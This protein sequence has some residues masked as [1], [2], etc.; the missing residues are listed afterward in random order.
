MV[1]VIST[2]FRVSNVKAFISTFATNPTYMA[3]GRTRPWVPTAASPSADDTNPPIAIDSGKDMVGYFRELIGAKRIGSADVSAAIP[4]FNWT[5]GTIYTQY[6]YTDQDITTKNMFVVINDSLSGSYLNVYKCI[7][8]ANGVASSIQPTGT[9]TSVIGPLADG[10]KWKFMFQI[11]SG[12]MAKF[13]TSKFLPIKEAPSGSLQEAVQNS[14]I[15]G[16]IDTITV[17]AP[18]T[19]YTTAPSI[20]ITGDGTGATAVASVLAGAITAITITNPGTG[21][22]YADVGIT[23]AG[24]GGAAYANIASQGG[25]GKNALNELGA[26]YVVMSCLMEFDEGGDIST[27]ND[28]RSTLILRNPKDPADVAFTGSTARL[29]TKVNFGALVGT[30]VVDEKVTASSGATGYVVEVGVGFLLLN[31]AKGVFAATN[32]LTGETSAAT[33]T[34][35]TVNAPEIKFYSGESFYMETREPIIRSVNQSERYN[36]VV[37]W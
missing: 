27:A 15:L 1:A 26:Y 22:T 4:R 8:N 35:N 10:Y 33:A 7:S 24:T 12:D 18:G 19:G 2:P 21:Y 17:T 37:Q 28:V 34:V 14:S 6:D 29:T 16:T 23:G 5:T 32:G 9:S 3:V 30:F 13:S 11:D 25:H 20:A 31:D 36:V